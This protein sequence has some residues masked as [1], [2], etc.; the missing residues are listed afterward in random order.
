MDQHIYSIFKNN[1]NTDKF[2][3]KDHY[4]VSISTDSQRFK[5]LTDEKFQEII[6]EVILIKPNVK[7]ASTVSNPSS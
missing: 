5:G 7:F 4:I 3:I 6:A 2:L 1:L